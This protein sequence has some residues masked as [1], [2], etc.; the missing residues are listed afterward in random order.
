MF[1]LHEIG[2]G[3]DYRFVCDKDL[4]FSFER[5]DLIAWRTDT[6]GFQM[7]ALTADRRMFVKSQAVISG[8]RMDDW[9]VEVIASDLCRQL[10]IPCVQQQPCMFL[11]AGHRY[12]GV[13]S[14]NFELDGDIFLSFERL[15]ERHGLSTREEDF[16]HLDSLSK[17]YWCAERLSDIS[18]LPEEDTL[19]YVLDLAVLDCL[20]GNVD[21]HTRNFGL[22]YHA[23]ESKYRIPLIF[24]NGMGL[25]EHDPYRDQYQSFEEAMRSVY[26]APYGEDP[27]ELLE[28]LDHEFD[29][30]RRYP[31]LRQLHYPDLLR[32]PFVLE[33]ERR[34]IERWQ[35]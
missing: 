13:C 9:A 34:M 4:T 28:L 8:L 35:R 25:F 11:Y 2:N 26:V 32:K 27:F 17:L 23:V 1:S 30:A 20:T 14:A 5:K 29:L 3:A 24:D 7:K 18:K 19:K 15:L 33:Y 12:R 21:R 16:I 31:G 22:F 10:G 6:D